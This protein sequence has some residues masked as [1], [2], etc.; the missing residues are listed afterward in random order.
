MSTIDPEQHASLIALQR[1]ANAAWAELD[2]H[3]PGVRGIDLSTEQRAEAKRLREQA[4]QSALALREGLYASG[5]V[6]EHGYYQVS[7]DLMAVAAREP[8]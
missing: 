1:E 5:L 2:A 4:C 7:Q 8:S 6:E 3:A